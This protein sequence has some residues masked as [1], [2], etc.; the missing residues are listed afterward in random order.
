MLPPGGTTTITSMP[1]STTVTMTTLASIGVDA[2]LVP[3]E[4][5]RVRLPP[6]EEPVS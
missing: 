3:L 5:A 4:L 6:C 2:M 1:T